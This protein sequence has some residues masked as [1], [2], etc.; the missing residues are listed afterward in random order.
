M[1]RRGKPTRLWLARDKDINGLWQY[2]IFSGEPFLTERGQWL[3]DTETDVKCICAEGWHRHTRIR[4]RPGQCV[5]VTVTQTKRGFR[6]EV[7]PRMR[8]KGK[9][10]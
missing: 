7:E 3:A 4:L 9:K 6:F 10:R 1:T 2:V 8:Q 5:R